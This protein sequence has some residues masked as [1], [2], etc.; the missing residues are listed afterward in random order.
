MNDSSSCAL[1]G[2]VNGYLAV[3]ASIVAR[4]ENLGARQASGRTRK[5]GE[6]GAVCRPTRGTRSQLRME[7]AGS[8]PVRAAPLKNGGCCEATPRK[9]WSGISAAETAA[10]TLTDGEEAAPDEFE[11]ARAEGGRASLFEAHSFPFTRSRR[12]DVRAPSP[13]PFHSM[14]S[15]VSVRAPPPR[16]ET[17]P[18]QERLGGAGKRRDEELLRALAVASAES[19]DRRAALNVETAAECESRNRSQQRSLERLPSL[20][21]V[22]ATPASS[23]APPSRASKEVSEDDEGSVLCPLSPNSAISLNACSSRQPTAIAKTA[24]TRVVDPRAASKTEKGKKTSAEGFGPPSNHSPFLAKKSLLALLPFLTAS[25]LV[26]CLRVCV[27]WFMA[28]H[29]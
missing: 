19:S 2:A 11:H 10:D 14:S 23:T 17:Q 29:G 9:V 27:Q 4:H 22:K 5:G 6:W 18:N 20:S 13:R 25:E 15:G 16:S 26:A 24:T 1:P 12:P 28:F 8:E 3:R 7:A 21:G